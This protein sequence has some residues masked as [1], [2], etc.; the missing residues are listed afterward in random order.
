MKCCTVST[1]TLNQFSAIS[2]E[3][4]TYQGRLMINHRIEN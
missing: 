2:K 1:N 4:P 3:T